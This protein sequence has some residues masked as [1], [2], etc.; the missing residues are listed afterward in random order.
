MVAYL[1]LSPARSSENV[2]LRTRHFFNF[3]HR[4]FC[5]AAIL[6]RDSLLIFR[7]FLTTLALPGDTS[8][9]FTSAVLSAASSLSSL[10][11]VVTSLSMRFALANTVVVFIVSGW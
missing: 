8:N 5:A 9:W 10:P 7:R 1:A 2:K 4:A 3:A 11:I 6:A